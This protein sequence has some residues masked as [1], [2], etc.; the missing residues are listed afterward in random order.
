MAESFGY[1]DLK[2]YDVHFCLVSAQ[3]AANYWPIVL[4]RPRKVVLFVT[5]T[6]AQKGI[7]KQLKESIKKAWV[8]AVEEI[9]I[10]DETDV[11]R[12]TDRFLTVLKR[13]DN[14]KVIFNLTCGTK[15]MVFSALRAAASLQVAGFYVN[16]DDNSYT[17]FP[18]CNLSQGTLAKA[19][20]FS[21]KF[22]SFLSAYG[23]EVEEKS[24]AKELSKAENLFFRNLFARDDSMHEAVACMNGLATTAD[25]KTRQTRELTEKEKSSTA[26]RNLIAQ[27]QEFA[28]LTEKDGRIVFSTEEKRKFVAGGWLEQYVGSCLMEIKGVTPWLNVK[29]VEEEEGK[30]PIISNEIDALFMFGPHLFLVEC[31]TGVMKQANN[32]DNDIVYKVNNLTKVGGLNT[33]L[34]VV[35]YRKMKA[36][37]K[38]RAEKL[39]MLVIDGEGLLTL[40]NQVEE[41]IKK[42][43]RQ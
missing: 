39:G 13:Y 6:M 5:E 32:H 14:R 38:R 4:Y 43:V 15:L 27:Y 25:K 26:L 1:I 29:I 2:E 30:A 20:E 19:A 10:A 8:G 28:Y 7:A 21:P 35:S 16:V 33:H 17:V 37:A 42:V 31:K 41:L 9:S 24:P 3:T 23:Y 18:K 22:E 40:N 11:N 34:I 12:M 36:V